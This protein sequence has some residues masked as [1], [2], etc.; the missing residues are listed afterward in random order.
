M[1]KNTNKK[2]TNAKFHL[3]DTG[4]GSAMIESYPSEHPVTKNFPF[5]EG[6]TLF[7]TASFATVNLLGLSR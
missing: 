1:V 7:T 2:K 6:H 4:F 3:F 5:F